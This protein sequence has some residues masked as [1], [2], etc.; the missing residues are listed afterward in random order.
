MFLNLSGFMQHR[1]KMA[2][3]VS[4]TTFSATTLPA[5]F[6]SRRSR[7][8]SSMKPAMK[9]GGASRPEPRARLGGT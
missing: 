6:S 4:F 9:P 7:C 2:F 1:P 3:W 8:F 5:S